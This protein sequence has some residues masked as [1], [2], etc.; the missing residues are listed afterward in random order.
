MASINYCIDRAIR[1]DALVDVHCDEIDDPEA[2][3][4]KCR[5]VEYWK[6]A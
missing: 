4:G 5:H 1:Y 2:K 3:G 6:L